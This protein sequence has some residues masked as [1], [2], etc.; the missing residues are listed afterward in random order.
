ML[1]PNAPQRCSDALLDLWPRLR[2]EL[3]LSSHTHLLETK[4][5]AIAARRRWPAGIVRELDRRGL[6]DEHLSVA[7]GI[8]LDRD[9]RALLAKRVV[10]VVHNPSSN[11]MLGSGAIDFIDYRA[12]GARLALGSDSANTGGGADP[13]ELMRLALMLPRLGEPDWRCW[14]S[15]RDV[16]RAAGEGAAAA[17]GHAD[18]LGRIEIGRL[19]DLAIIDLASAATIA[20]RFSPESIVQHGGAAHVCATLIG[21]DFAYRDDRILAFDAIA[22]RD[23]FRDRIEEFL[24]RAAPAHATAREALDVFAAQLDVMNS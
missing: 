12:Q 11:L 23:G 24:D 10:T 15:A 13:F 21:G 4:A 6:L 20:P 1:G 16:L 8:W 7:H 18:E 9:E 17:L 3:G 2:D 22:V 14:P 5:Q 19:A